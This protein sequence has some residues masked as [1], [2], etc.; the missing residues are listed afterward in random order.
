[1][2]KIIDEKLGRN[3]LVET[4]SKGPRSFL[5]AYNS[6]VDR[7]LLVFDLFAQK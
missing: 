5:L 6:L 2:S 7:K 4:I 3:V 1:M